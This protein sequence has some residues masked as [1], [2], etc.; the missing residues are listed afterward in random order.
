MLVGFSIDIDEDEDMPIVNIKGEI[1]VYTCPQ[2]RTAL[3][4]LIEKG[5]QSFIINMESI[6]YIDSTGLGT[7]AHTAQTVKAK[8]GFIH[9]I[10]NKP[11]IIKIFEVSG[12]QKK[13]IKLYD[14]ETAVMKALS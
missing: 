4:S 10:C 9:I 6:Q 13:N 1:D 11:Q 12:L 14:S 7:I 8:D 5:K 3:S 2:L